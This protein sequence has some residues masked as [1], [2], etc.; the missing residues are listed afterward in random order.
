[1]AKSISSLALG[2]KIKDSK[3]NIF[4]VIAH[5]H[6]GNGETVLWDS[7]Y[8]YATK[9]A[10]TD[11]V[12]TKYTNTEADY[13]LTNVYPGRLPSE[14]LD[15]VN[16]TSIQIINPS[17]GG[18]ETIK[19][20]YFLLSAT[21]LYGNEG[22]HMDSEII[23]SKFSYF[24]NKS[25]INIS[26]NSHSAY[27]N[28][29][30]TRTP[31][32][33]TPKYYLGVFGS[34]YNN[35]SFATYSTPTTD[36]LGVRAT[37]TVSNVLVTDNV[38]NGCYSFVFNQPPVV[39]DIQSIEGNYGTPTAITYVAIDS[40]DNNLIHYF[41]KDN[42]SSW[43]EISPARV[44]NSYTFSYLFNELNTY[45]CRIKVVDSAENSTTSNM[46]SVSVNEANPT[47]N[48]LSVEDKTVTFKVNC[49]TSE[50]SKVEIFI[51]NILVETI[52]NGFNSSLS[53]VLN[54]KDL[55]QGKNDITIKATSRANLEGTRDFE[56]NK[57]S[58]KLPPV[59]TKVIINNVEYTI[60][61]AFEDNGL[62]N[63]TLD[64]QL[65][66]NVNI[67]DEISIL[68][69]RIKVKC[70]LSNISNIKDFK[71]MKLVKSKKLKGDFEGYIEEKYELEA[72]GR[73]SSI[74]LELEK[75]NDNIDTGIIELQQYFDY[76]ED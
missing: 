11:Y 10:S 73:Y 8:T 1:M 75:F 6:Y 21:E 40:D 19:R 35:S 34:S 52:T 53:Y 72:E 76:M 65:A 44:N 68:Q 17:N 29:L 63:Y 59:G 32:L 60:I 54:S 56:A 18:K 25:N 45:S 70:G 62:H 58:C 20:K 37:F 27:G 7:N 42:G 61:R 66:S 64:T 9:L 12:Y 30:W 67:N 47:V 23:G 36:V 69:D 41:S 15:C 55:I 49:I 39:E 13:Y 16:D 71:E 46:F 26:G 48:I 51:N 2:S 22:V 5:N 57:S 3:G 43:E 24:N 28:A 38:S 4:T 14:L 33:D 50:I 31:C 74:K